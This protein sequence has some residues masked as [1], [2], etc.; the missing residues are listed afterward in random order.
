MSKIVSGGSVIQAARS[1]LARMT[2]L[3]QSE[4]C[5]PVAAGADITARAVRYGFAGS[6]EVTLEAP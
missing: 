5:V 4:N 1:R 6:E 2:A 3:L